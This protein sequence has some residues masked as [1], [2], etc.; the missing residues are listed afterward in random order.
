MRRSTMVEIWRGNIGE[1][2]I[3]FLWMIRLSSSFEQRLS[4][5][6]FLMIQRPPRSTLS[7]SSATSDVYKGQRLKAPLGDQLLRHWKRLQGQT[8]LT[9][10]SYT[11]PSPRDRTR[12][13]MPSSAWKNKTHKTILELVCRLLLEK[14][15]NQH[16]IIDSQPPEHSTITNPICHTNR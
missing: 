8:S 15:K 10:R 16:V 6:L 12:A 9:C 14:N 5:S 3:W 2:I 11:S 1:G 7:S 13:R 4:L